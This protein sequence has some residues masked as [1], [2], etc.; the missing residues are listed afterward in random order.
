MISTTCETK[1]KRTEAS[2]TASFVGLSGFPNKVGAFTA[3]PAVNF[4]DILWSVRIYPGGYDESSAKH[5]S[6]YVA[7]DCQGGPPTRASF[8]ISIMNQKVLGSQL[9]VL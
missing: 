1:M 8:R 9:G 3:S 4:E 5:L 7:C 6:C 2:F